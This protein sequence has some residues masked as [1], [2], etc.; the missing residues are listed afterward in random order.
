MTESS[1]ESQKF[2]AV[3]RKVLSVSYD[4]LKAGCPT[5]SRR[6]ECVGDIT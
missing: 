5:H 4:E 3:V 2:D 6:L 1:S